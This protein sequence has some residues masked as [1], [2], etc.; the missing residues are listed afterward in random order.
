MLN[1]YDI[2]TADMPSEMQS[3]LRQY[4]RD[5]WDAHPGFREKTQ[6]WMNAHAMFRRLS[7]SVRA[8]TE[9]FLDRNME[10]DTYADRLSYRGNLLVGNLHGHH[11]WEDRSYFPEL[12]AA[13]SRFEAGLE[14]LEK[15]HADLDVV[16]EDFTR[17]ANRTIKLLHLDIPAARDEAGQLHGTS[18]TIDAFLARH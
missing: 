6:Q 1:S 15:D 13:E 4:P 5:S 12:I 18:L 2:R 14:I 17:L 8:D 10:A 7:A 11:N 3:L 9:A 16:L